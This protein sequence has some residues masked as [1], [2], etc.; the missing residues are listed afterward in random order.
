MR[1]RSAKN[2]E[3]ESIYETRDDAVYYP[4]EM[5]RFWTVFRFL[6]FLPI[7]ALLLLGFVVAG[8]MN[9]LVF[10]KEGRDTIRRWFINWWRWVIGEISTYE[11]IK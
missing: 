5:R 2:K 3:L 6:I 7:A 4:R 10:S 1:P 9:L 11:L 8:L